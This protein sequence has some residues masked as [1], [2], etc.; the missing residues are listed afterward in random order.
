MKVRFTPRARQR[1][2][3]VAAWWREN[4]PDVADLFDEELE[5]AT[6]R[7]TASGGAVYETIHGNAI[8]RLLL[9]KTAQHIYYSID[10][11]S[12]TV[13]VHTIWGA[14]RGQGPKL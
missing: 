7:L 11:A 14:R 12:D 2:R 9:P 10:D 3:G 1:A 13:V 5:S 8:R 6:G 4:R